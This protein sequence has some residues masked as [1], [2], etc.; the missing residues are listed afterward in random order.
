MKEWE[1]GRVRR[2]EGGR[3]GEKERGGKRKHLSEGVGGRQRGKE[4][5]GGK[6]DRG[7]EGEREAG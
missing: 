1:G 5:G 7:R 3:E 2:R 4:E 6:K